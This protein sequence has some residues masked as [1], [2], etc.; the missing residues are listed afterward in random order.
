[1]SGANPGANYF[2][3]DRAIDR[4]RYCQR[5][6]DRFCCYADLSD[7]QQARAHQKLRADVE[8][9]ERDAAWFRHQLDDCFAIEGL[10]L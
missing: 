5:E 1:M 8:R 7:E 9:A 3:L 2:S 10:N 4:V 6:F